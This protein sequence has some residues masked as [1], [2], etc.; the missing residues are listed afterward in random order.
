[1]SIIPTTLLTPVLAGTAVT[2]G[3]TFANPVMGE[4]PS[5]WP[6]AD[7]STVTMTFIAGTGAEAVVWTYGGFGNIVRVSTGIYTA[8]LDTTDTE[9]QWQVKWIGTGACAAVWVG[10]FRVTAQPF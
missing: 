8:E 4:V 2:T 5:S 10:G 1:M 3:V 6:P 7:P 9:G